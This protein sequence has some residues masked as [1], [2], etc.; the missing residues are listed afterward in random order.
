MLLFSLR[1]ARPYWRW[2]LIV[3]FAMVVETIM[4]LASPWP[5]KIVLDS[6]LDAQPVRGWWE[7][8]TGP[9]PGP[10]ALLTVAAI[11]TVAIALLQAGS[12]YLAGSSSGSRKSET[13][14]LLET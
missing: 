11:A 4:T 1:L 5:L 10:L 14:S 9:Q 8:A 7:W 3:A 12:A 2:L 13:S 6:V